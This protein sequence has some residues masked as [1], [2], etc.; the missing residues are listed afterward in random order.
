MCCKRTYV[1]LCLSYARTIHKFQ[2]LSA[3]P[4]DEGKIPNMFECIICDP[5]KRESE[6][7]ALGLFYTALSRATTLGD[8]DGL[9]SAMY[10][11]GEQFD[12]ARIRNIGRMKGTN[13]DY[14]R[15]KNRQKWIEHLQKNTKTTSLSSKKRVRI[16]KWAETER[17]TETELEDRCDQYV[18][19]KVIR[20]GC[21][22]NTKQNK[23]H[24]R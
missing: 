20:T 6:N 9:N 2:G 1:P 11:N 23:R 21:T 5:D 8:P 10:F 22:N 7:I 16:L 13:E 19:A 14:K 12:E 3:G 18:R 17:I 15:V 24:K 4:V